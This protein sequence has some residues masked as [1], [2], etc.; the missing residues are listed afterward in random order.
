MK[1]LIILIV[2]VF[3]QVNVYG[4]TTT[5]CVESNAKEALIEK[6]SL[7]PEMSNLR[8]LSFLLSVVKGRHENMKKEGMEITKA[9]LK[10]FDDVVMEAEIN[11]DN[12]LE[13]SPEFKSLDP[14]QRGEVFNAAIQKNAQ[15][16]LKK[17][18]TCLVN[19]KEVKDCFQDAGIVRTSVFATCVTITGAADI[20]L[21]IGS[22]G[23]LTLAL[24]NIVPAE[25]EFCSELAFTSSVVSCILA[26]QADVICCIGNSFGYN[27]SVCN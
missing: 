11:F 19:L 4:N 25:L 1:K 22:D 27:W 7:T 17:I 15:E 26:V 10:I 13:A 23:T 20:A 21:E 14:A 24:S 16:D 18:A 9:D 8:Q 3:L 6:L 12:L 2:A 5:E